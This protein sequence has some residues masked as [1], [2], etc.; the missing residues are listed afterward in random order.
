[1]TLGRVCSSETS[2]CVLLATVSGILSRL[3]TGCGEATVVDFD[4]ATRTYSVNSLAMDA[5]GMAM[6]PGSAVVCTRWDGTE[7]MY[8]R[9][10]AAAR[11]RGRSTRSRER[12]GS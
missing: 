7:E 11:R 5:R 9:G 6:V 8:S 12:T 10:S 3:A 4:L 1:M 2:G